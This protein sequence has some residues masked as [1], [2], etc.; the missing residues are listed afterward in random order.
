M[1]IKIQARSHIGAAVDGIL[2]IGWIIDSVPEGARLNRNGQ[3]LRLRWLTEERAFRLFI[4]KV[5]DRGE[6][7]RAG[8][9]R[10][11][12]TST[13]QK[14]LKVEQDYR[15]VVLGYDPITGVFVGIDSR[16]I[17]LGGSTGN[18]SSNV[19]PDGVQKATAK[20][21]LI[22][23]HQS[24]LLGS[25]YQAYFKP[26][27]ITEYLANIETIHLGAYEGRGPFSGNMRRTSR[28]TK[29]ADRFQVS[30]KD[31]VLRGPLAETKAPVWADK[32]LWK[33]FE[34]D[35][36][37][38]L[39]KTRSPVDFLE[40]YKRQLEIGTKGELHVLKH[41][42]LRLVAARRPDLAA[43]VSWV[44]AKKPFE[45]YDI[46]SY[47]ADG[48]KRFIE[49]KATTGR[50]RRFPISVNEWSVAENKGSSYVIYRVTSVEATPAIRSFRDP[51]SL[52]AQGKLQLA[53][54]D[55]CIT[56]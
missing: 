26:A 2:S 42:R 33:A 24:N 16:R 21:V 37:K 45:G 38:D 10:I 40:L 41:E 53:A 19:S 34:T 7:L 3:H 29:D 4:Y 56:Y 46:Q 12:I 31:L 50:S 22:L 25:E 27:K 18:A 30:G 32:V 15:D 13:Y 55:W 11:E 6:P 36:I 51:V 49:V 14:N 44:A 54:N 35:N 48:R 43:K 28:R 8:E 9:R 17:N 47:E 5:T 39:R 52:V 20:S 23:P 1:P